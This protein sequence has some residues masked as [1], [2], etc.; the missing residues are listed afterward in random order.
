MKTALL[1]STYNWPEALALVLKSVEQQ[2]QLPDELLIADDGSTQET[3]KLI[4]EFKKRTRIHVIHVWHEDEGFK[5]SEILNKTV[6]QSNA[7]YLIQTDGDCI[8]HRNFIKDHKSFAK[9]GLYLYGSRVNIKQSHLDTLFSES[10][11]NFS[12]FSKGIK[13]RTRALHIPILSRLYGEKKELSK[14]LRG[15]N[16]SFWRADFIAVNGYNEDMTGWGR[17]DSELVIR[18]VNYGITGR[19][20]R[21]RGIVFHI[22]HKTSSKSKLNINESIQQRAIDE[23]LTRCKNGIDKYL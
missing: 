20:L 14:K 23:N 3:T 18:M 22:F 19:R 5:R 12:A 17:E 1:V 21:Y 7:D 11:T 16:V 6:A 8:L 15:C 9:K 13:K 10:Q 2:S 4:E